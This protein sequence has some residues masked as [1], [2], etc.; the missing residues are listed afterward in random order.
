MPARPLARGAAIAAAAD[1][2][3]VT[4]T[5]TEAQRVAALAMVPG[6]A[7]L[8]ARRALGRLAEDRGEQLTKESKLNKF[9]RVRGGKA[10]LA[11]L[12]DCPEDVQVTMETLDSDKEVE[13]TT[14]TMLFAASH[15]SAAVVLLDEDKFARIAR[16]IQFAGSLGGGCCGTGSE[17]PAR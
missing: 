17:A 10:A 5:L 12:P 1:S 3:R 7:L 9:G 8:E 16:T 13:L 4:V 2:R 15:Q 6:A 11:A 14:L